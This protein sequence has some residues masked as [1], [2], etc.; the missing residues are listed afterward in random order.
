[1]IF[2][3]YLF[4][5]LSFFKECFLFLILFLFSDVNY[6]LPSMRFILRP[7]SA[8][9]ELPHM[10]KPLKMEQCHKKDGSVYYDMPIKKY[11]LSH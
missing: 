2:G 11:L 10:L 1:M 8:S 4:E 7:K 5:D 6:D 3:G 9:F